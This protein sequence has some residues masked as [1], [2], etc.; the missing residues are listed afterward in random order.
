MRESPQSVVGDK[1]VGY[2]MSTPAKGEG[3]KS[4]TLDGLD[5]DL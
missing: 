2:W 5:I 4:R 3:V 1:D